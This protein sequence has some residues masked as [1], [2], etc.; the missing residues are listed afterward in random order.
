MEYPMSENVSKL[1]GY[2]GAIDKIKKEAYTS[3]QVPIS[4]Q[5]EESSNFFAK[6]LVEQ[7]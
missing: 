2:Y 4:L 7:I 6:P 3:L 1:L 5:L